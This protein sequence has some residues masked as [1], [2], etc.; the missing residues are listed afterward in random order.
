MYG[1]DWKTS[2]NLVEFA[3]SNVQITHSSPPPRW[4]RVRVGGSRRWFQELPVACGK[5]SRMPK[6]SCG[7]NC[8]ISSWAAIGSGVSTQC[9][10]TW[11]ISSACLKNLS[12]RSMAGSTRS[13]PM[14]MKNA[15]G[16]LKK[17]GFASSASGTTRC[18]KIPTGW[19]KLLERPW[20][21][22][23]NAPTLYHP[24]T[25]ALPHE[26][27]GSNFSIAI[28]DGGDSRGLAKPRSISSLCLH[29]S[30]VTKTHA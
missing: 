29:V 26:G 2:L 24:P 17:T 9:A 28:N 30:V 7:H 5:T 12:S 1:G 21:K 25:P 19:L 27:G 4:G 16:L 11:S 13:K 8:A 20:A 3:R 23:V 22:A 14:R 18:C 6:E 10:A 15:H